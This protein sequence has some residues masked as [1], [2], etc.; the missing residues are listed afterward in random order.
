MNKYIRFQLIYNG[1]MRKL[2]LEEK[3]FNYLTV[4]KRVENTS[5]GQTRWLTRCKCG[6]Q[7]I[8][9]GSELIS[10]KTKSCGCLRKEKLKSEIGNRYG[11]LTVIGYGKK[12]TTKKVRY[13]EVKC[14]CGTISKVRGRHLKNGSIRSCGCIKSF[15]E[16]KITEILEKNNISYKK[17]IFFQ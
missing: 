6:K 15:G 4:I 11:K 16:L 9:I 2:D 10:S 8:V 5:G 7:T 17:T 3:K 14:D 1:I 13:W 12:T